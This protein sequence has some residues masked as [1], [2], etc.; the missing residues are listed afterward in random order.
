[1]R[2]NILVARRILPEAL[3][4]MQAV[5]DILMGDGEGSPPRD[6][7][8]KHLPTTDALFVAGGDKVDAALMDAG[9]RLR[10][11]SNMAVGY[12]N[13]DV[14]AATARGIYVGNTPGVLTDTTA[15]LTF[16]LLM[17]LARRFPEMERYARDG[18]WPG[19]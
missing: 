16:G 8:L 14:A 9:P 5:G 17:A 11:I 6:W 7:L 2:P 4:P 3:P 10:V 18:Q 1:M 19:Y 12:N 13:I 15:D